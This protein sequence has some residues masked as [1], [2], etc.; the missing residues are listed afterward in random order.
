MTCNVGLFNLLTISMLFESLI[1][2]VDLLVVW[3]NGIT[4]CCIDNSALPRL[5]LERFNPI[6][7]IKIMSVITL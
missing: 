3:L 2:D 6:D 7:S 1:L 5:I 4:D